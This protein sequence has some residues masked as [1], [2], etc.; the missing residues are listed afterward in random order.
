[1][2]FICILFFSVFSCFL[3]TAQSFYLRS[4]KNYTKFKFDYSTGSSTEL[5]VVDY[6][7]THA[8]GFST[9]FP[10]KRVN[11]KGK[12]SPF[13]IELG[14]I[15]NNFSSSVGIQNASYS[16]KTNYLSFT[17][18]FLVSLFRTKR[19]AFDLRTGFNVGGLIYGK[20][21]INGVIYDLSKVPDFKGLQ[22]S[23]S[24][25][26]Q[27]SF[28]ATDNIGVTLGYDNLKSINT[29]TQYPDFFLMDTQQVLFGVNFKIL[30]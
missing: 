28:Q 13:S 15:L 5:L 25:G 12:Q 4:G 2:R 10:S 23:G 30:E 18:T 27:L 22:F 9:P 21:N 11:S 7:N 24:A 19:L 1:M 20:E 16:W 26:L 3:S 8:I 6:G 14:L 17:N 29:S